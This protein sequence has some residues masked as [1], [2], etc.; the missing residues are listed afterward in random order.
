MI[1]GMR[2]AKSDVPSVTF[3]LLT[4]APAKRWKFEDYD[5][6]KTWTASG[7]EIR[8]KGFEIAIPNRRDSR[9][10]FYS[11]DRTGELGSSR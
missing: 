5:S 9:V 2:R 7:R 3:D 1:L 11:V 4:I 10:I 6:G 8:E